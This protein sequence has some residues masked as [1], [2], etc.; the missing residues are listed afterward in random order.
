MIR[1]LKQLWR[2]IIDDPRPGPIDVSIP[3]FRAEF[4]DEVPDDLSP[5]YLYLVGE[6][7]HYWCA[8]MLCPCGC[9][10]Q[11]QLSLVKNDRPRWQFKVDHEN[12]PSLFPSVWRTV[13]CRSHFI[14]RHGGVVWCE[15]TFQ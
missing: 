14:L 6:N 4:A 9:N 5:N 1:T 11:I 10:A 12:R 7:K 3:T 8:A 2:W 13:G 15:P